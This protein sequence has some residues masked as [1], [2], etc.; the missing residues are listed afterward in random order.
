MLECFD[1]L[2]VDADV[3]TP[4]CPRHARATFASFAA[5]AMPPL[6]HTMPMPLQR[7][8]YAMHHYYAILRCHY[9]YFDIRLFTRFD[10]DYR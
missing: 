4:R 7:S 8:L 10:A 9:Y 3:F 1:T 6:C 2:R 5:H